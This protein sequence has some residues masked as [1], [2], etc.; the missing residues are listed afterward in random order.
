MKQKRRTKRLMALALLLASVLGLAGG[1]QIGG[2]SLAGSEPQAMP[3]FRQPLLIQAPG[4]PDDFQPIIADGRLVFS[5][6]LFDFDVQIF[7]SSRSSQLANCKEE[8]E[9]QYWTAAEIVK[10]NAHYFSINPQVLLT[11]LQLQSGVVDNPASDPDALDY[12]M[13]YYSPEFSGLYKQV[14]WAAQQL[15]AGFYGRK[16]HD[17]DKALVFKDGTSRTADMDL[18]PGTFALHYMLAK[19]TDELSWKGLVG[20][21]SGSFYQTFVEL[22]GDPL[23]DPNASLPIISGIPDSILPWTVGET[24]Y[25]TGGPHNYNGGTVGCTSGP[26]CPRPW[27]AVD[28]APPEVVGCSPG[29]TSYLGNRW[30]VAA[31][32]GS[33]IYSGQALVKI[34][35]GDG[36]A[37]YYSH[38]SSTNRVGYGPVSQGDHVGHPSCEV[39]PGGWTLGIHVHF[40]TSY[41]GAFVDINGTVLSGWEIHESTHYNGTMTRNGTTRWADTGRSNGTNDVYNYG[42]S[43]PDTTPPTINV[44]QQPPT[45]V[46][47][48]Y[49]GYIE[50]HNS[51]ASGLSAQAQNWGSDPG[52]P[53]TSSADWGY[54]YFHYMGDPIPEGGPFYHYVRVWDNSPNHNSALSVQGPFYID[55]TGPTIDFYSTPQ[56]NY[57]YNTNQRVSWRISD[58]GSGWLGFSQNW[59]SDP[60]GTSPQFYTYEGFMDFSY[61]PEAQRD[62]KHW[63]Y[64]R[65]WDQLGNQSM[66][67]SGEYWYDAT[68]PTNPSVIINGDAAYTNNRNVSLALSASD[69]TSGVSQMNLRNEGESWA[70]WRGYQSPYSWTLP[71][72]DGTKTVHAQF[73]DAADNTS[74]TDSDSIILDTTPPGTTIIG[75]PQGDIPVGDVCFSWTGSDN[76]TPTGDLVYRYRLLG[77]SDIWSD[78][79]GDTNICYSDL[80]DGD[81][82]FEVKARDLAGNED[83]SPATRTF[84]VDV[85][86]PETTI[87][88]GSSGCIGTANVTFTWTGSDNRTSTDQLQYSYKLEGFDDWS[89]WTGATSKSYTSLSDGDYTFKVKARDGVGHEDPSPAARSFRTD[90]TPPTGSILINGGDS[91]TNKITVHLDITGDDGPVGCGVTE[92]RLS[93]DDHNW[94]AWQPFA[95]EGEWLLPTLNRTTWTV[96]LQLKDLVGNVSGAFTDDI[97]LDLYPPRPASESYQLGARVV[98]SG[99]SPSN[100]GSYKL[101]SATMGQPIAD[102]RMQGTDYRLESGY[103]GAWPSVPRGR[104]TP[105]SY[106]INPSVMASSGGYQ[107]SES[108]WLWG[109]AGQPADHDQPS[110]ENYQMLSGYWGMQPATPTGTPTVTPT[111]TTTTTLTP[112]S[113]PTAT[114]TNTPTDMPTPTS[115]PTSTPTATPTPTLTPT[116][117]STPVPTDTST[118]THT[119][120]P[121]STPTDT[122][123]ATPTATPTG[124]VTPP[125]N[126]IYLPIVL[127]SYP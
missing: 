48:N 108:Y 104:L 81:Y 28:Y 114:P 109:T 106:D 5:P 113:T 85:T 94:E 59:D 6:A 50:W 62:G 122:P 13:G 95:T 90:T 61:I 11:L 127:K 100:S 37:T 12:A 111:N 101:L 71:S 14:N 72:G 110:S 3:L 115:T 76:I 26:G 24:W 36:W 116:V 33:V 60:G 65:A 79:D 74:P 75:G 68:A 20:R 121:T 35:H 70:G 88:S 73:K 63:A 89:A 119:P 87:A 58:G 126:L 96:H 86:P 84:G 9:Q 51:D 91:T 34:D 78:W 16:Y 123:T 40:A 27:S 15:F 82:T 43:G 80:S 93:N 23:Q 97:Y 99:D 21:G 57:W 117:T 39:E 10:F 92:M 56:T 77:S 25:Y 18:T 19:T 103:Q 67:G 46:W 42:S 64:V 31:R 30:I 4:A 120:T 49:D 55:A 22:F 102:G 38:V 41:D 124:T 44:T 83:L 32:S 107:A 118:A 52:D 125:T 53:Q 17:G 7:L 1:S 98:A 112:T 29:S 54:T 45:G 66:E 8:I 47:L 2:V 105:E 69:P